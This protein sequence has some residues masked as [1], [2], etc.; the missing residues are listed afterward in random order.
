MGRDDADGET[1]VRSTLHLAHNLGLTVV[2]EGVE[3][4]EVY[5]T[6]AS[7]GCDYAQGYLVSRPMPNE[8]LLA[9]LERQKTDK[10]RAA[11]PELADV[12]ALSYR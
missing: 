6:L 5:D 8:E 1:I 12:R 9:W 3:T 4:A 7:L 11:V 10:H 2:A